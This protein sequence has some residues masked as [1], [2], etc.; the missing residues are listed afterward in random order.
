MSLFP[1]K[2]NLH[3]LQ[4][5]GNEFH[6]YFSRDLSSSKRFPTIFLV[7][8]TSRVLEYMGIARCR[9]SSGNFTS[10]P[11]SRHGG[12]IPFG[13]MRYKSLL[14]IRVKLVKP[15]KN[16]ALTSRDDSFKR[17]LQSFFPKSVVLPGVLRS[18]PCVFN[19]KISVNK[20]GRSF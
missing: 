10:E 3:F 17:P 4:L 11:G 15:I 16:G 1:W 18:N 20:N 19:K 14:K 12:W 13:W 5:G 7:A 8:T 2:S 6:P 9:C